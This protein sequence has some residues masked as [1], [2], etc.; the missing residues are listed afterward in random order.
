MVMAVMLAVLLLALMVLEALLSAEVVLNTPPGMLATVDVLSD[1]V[2]NACT[3]T[4]IG[5]FIGVVID[6]LADVNGTVS[7][8][9][10]SALE[11]TTMPAPLE[12]FIWWTGWCISTPTPVWDCNRVLQT[13]MPSYHVCP[14][15]ELPALPQFR[16][17]EPSRPQQLVLPDFSMAP[18]LRHTEL[19]IVVVTAG[20]VD[21]SNGQRHIEKNAIVDNGSSDY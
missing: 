10:A 18:H 2:P 14:K 7:A 15:F 8:A 4:V 5:T 12:A 6:V 17:Q 20:G 16:N 1:S 19:M 13:L 3:G 21:V 9:V 11:C